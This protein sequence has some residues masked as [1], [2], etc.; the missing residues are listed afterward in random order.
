MDKNNFKKSI[1]T[2]GISKNIQNTK[3]SIKKIKL[4]SALF[5]YIFLYNDLFISNYKYKSLLSLR[6]LNSFCIIIVFDTRPDV[7][8]MI[9]IIKELK[10]NKKFICITINTGQHQKMANKILESLNMT[11]YVDIE[12]NVMRKNQTLSKLTSRIILELDKIYSLFNPKSIIVQGDTTTIVL[13]LLFLH[14][15]KRSLFF[16]LNQDL[17]PKIYYLLFLKNLIG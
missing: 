13:L 6:L 4:L 3:I 17:G 15:I 7:L 2:I 12:L 16:M 8:K 9:P 1:K 11:Q 14:F 10:S 5:L